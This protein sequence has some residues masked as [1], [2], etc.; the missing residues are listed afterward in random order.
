[1][2]KILF[3]IGFF[4]AVLGIESQAQSVPKYAILKG[5]DKYY[6][7]LEVMPQGQADVEW[8]PTSVSPECPTTTVGQTITLLHNRYDGVTYA[9]KKLNGHPVSIEKFAN[10]TLLFRQRENLVVTYRWQPKD[11]ETIY[12]S[13][14]EDIRRRN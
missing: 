3:L 9:I 5:G 4:L 8:V 6:S 14:G 1:M 10:G 11:N 2:S 7:V 12:K 13:D